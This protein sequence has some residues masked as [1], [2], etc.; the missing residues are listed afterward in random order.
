MVT[1]Y[2]LYDGLYHMHLV[3]MM[4][5]SEVFPGA[6][7]DGRVIEV[8]HWLKTK[9]VRDFE[10]VSLFCDQLTQVGPSTVNGEFIC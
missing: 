9:G 8:R 2:S 6:D 1:I 4:K 7:S 10:S 3:A 5:A